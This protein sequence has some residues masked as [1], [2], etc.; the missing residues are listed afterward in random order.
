MFSINERCAFVE[1]H[2]T[3]CIASATLPVDKAVAYVIQGTNA[4]ACARRDIAR[5]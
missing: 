4:T 5:V 1:I 2:R 3:G